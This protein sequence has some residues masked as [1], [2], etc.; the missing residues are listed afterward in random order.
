LFL[1]TFCNAAKR[2]VATPSLAWRNEAE[3]YFAL[4]NRISRLVESWYRRFLG[5]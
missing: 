3:L 4:Q 2:N 1:S 5:L